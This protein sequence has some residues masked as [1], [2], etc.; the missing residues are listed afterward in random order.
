MLRIKEVLKEK[1][2]T[3]KDLA[4]MLGITNV[5]LSRIVNGNTTIETLRKIAYVLDVDVRDLIEP[6]KNTFK[7]PLFIKDD[8]G[9]LLE[10]GTLNFRK[11]QSTPPEILQE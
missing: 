5:A 11:S 6:T 10:V 4:I 3:L 9:V 7:R 8:N 2:I 1:G